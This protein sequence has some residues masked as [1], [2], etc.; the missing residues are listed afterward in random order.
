MSEK[1]ERAVE[2]MRGS[3]NCS[4]AVMCAFCEDM[5]ISHDEAMEI[6]KPYAGGRKIKCGAVCAAEIVL[7]AKYGES[8]STVLHDEFEKEFFNKV[9]AINCK[10]IRRQNLCSCADCVKYSAEILDEMISN[11]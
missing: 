10:D 4:Q 9:G 2:Y 1:V 11:R 3:Y 8:S 7:T 6:A 5:G